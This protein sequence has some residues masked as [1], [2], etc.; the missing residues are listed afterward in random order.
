MCVFVG[1]RE[2]NG[3]SSAAGFLSGPLGGPLRPLNDSNSYGG[4][5]GCANMISDDP[6]TDE[7]FSLAVNRKEQVFLKKF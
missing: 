1:K 7:E 4:T 6:A 2:G 3:G 5:S